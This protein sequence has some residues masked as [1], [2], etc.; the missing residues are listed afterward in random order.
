MPA[1]FAN[2]LG[3][4][5][6]LKL[7]VA[8]CVFASS[9]QAAVVFSRMPETL[10]LSY[11]SLS[12]QANQLRAMGQYVQL[13]G[14]ERY[15]NAVT[16]TMVTYAKQSDYQ[17]NPL[18]QNSAG[19]NHYVE[20]VI[21][22]VDN[23]GASPVL[24]Y[25]ASSGRDVLIP[26]RPTVVPPGYPETGTSPYP[27]EGFAFNLCFQFDGSVQIPNQLVVSLNYDT[28]NY[29]YEPMNAPGPFNQLNV[30]ME[31]TGNTGLSVESN[32]TLLDS[33]SYLSKS[34]DGN[35]VDTMS[36][37]VAGLPMFKIEA[38]AT[39]PNLSP[40]ASYAGNFGLSGSDAAP[41]A[42]PDH[43]GY[44]N[45][46]EYAFGMNPASASGQLQPL[47]VF[48]E[49]NVQHGGM[50]ENLCVAT[51]LERSDVVYTVRAT[52]S[53]DGGFP[54]TIVPTIH[55]NQTGVPS[56]YTRYKA[57]YNSGV[58]RGFIKVEATV[59]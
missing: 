6:L 22:A 41:D 7:G 53:L 19:W 37:N 55:P 32:G 4:F 42:D 16:V 56:G 47:E 24:N 11:Q 59:P 29:G 3:G 50:V 28:Q 13:G 5:N 18:Y 48:S 15:L 20:A 38:S 54:T 46:M 14:T 10:D 44:S 52:S 39:P 51:F 33:R 2:R 8:L 23:S 9:A 12:F 58:D 45:R 25:V 26:W 1:S 40:I 30:G 36:G 17:A 21:Y 49:Q 34:V 43:D 57:V 27:Y 31:G 35:Y